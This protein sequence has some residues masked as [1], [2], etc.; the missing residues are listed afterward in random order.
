[1]TFKINLIN[2]TKKYKTKPRI[3][4][5]DSL[6]LIKKF[7]KKYHYLNNHAFKIYYVVEFIRKNKN[8]KYYLL[9]GI[10]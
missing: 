2:Q 9:V 7:A 5:F 6:S 1:M 8:Q 3:I 4:Q 10:I